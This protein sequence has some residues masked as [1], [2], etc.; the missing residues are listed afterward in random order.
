MNIPTATYRLQLNADFGFQHA[1]GITSY[2][3][4]LGISH[5]YAS[6]IFKARK[7]SP[8]GYDGVDPNQLNPE[9][10]S[11]EGFEK[12]TAGLQKHGIG[13]L[14]D[15]VP[16]HMAFDYEN[17]VLRDVLENGP[18]SQY[19]DFFDIAWDHPD[20]GMHRRLLAPFLGRPYSAC[21]ENGEIKL[22]YNATGFAVVY[23]DLKL[24]L[25]MASYLCILG[26]RTE[27][28]ETKLGA[29][30]EAFVRFIDLLD[31]LESLLLPMDPVDRRNQVQSI[32]ESLWDLYS[33]D[34]TIKN[35]VD[36]NLRRFNDDRT[37]SGQY[38]LL[39]QILSQ[40]MFRL[41]HWKV[42]CDEINYRRFFDI[43]ELITL[44]QEKKVVFDH[45]H[46]L[47]TNLVGD[48][49]VS[50][51]RI[52][53]IDGLRHPTDYLRRLRQRLG[54]IYVVVEKILDPAE[55]LPDFWPVQGTTGYEFS[56][57]VNG[58][59]IRH[60]NENKITEIYTR[61]SQCHD[62]FETV[63]A[64]CKRKVL[65]SQMA[66][67]LDNL[68]GV[69]KRLSARTRAGRD[70]TMRRLKDALTEILVRFPVY[71]TYIEPERLRNADDEVIRSAV[72]LSVLHRPDWRMELEF[73]QRLLLGEFGKE[74]NGGSSESIMLQRDMTAKFQQLTAPLMA[75]GME[76]TALYV[77]N[78]LLSLNEVGDHPS[79]FGCRVDAFHAFIKK[80]AEKWPY[81][82]N[83]TA[84]H[85]SKRGEDVRAR[86]NVLTEIPEE[87]EAVLK[88]WHVLN[89][90]KKKR[91]NGRKVPDKNE[92]YVL[93]QTL[94]G[95]FPL[96]AVETSTLVDRIRRYLIKA[97]REAKVHTSWLNPDETYEVALSS[98][99]EA[100]L[101][102]SDQSQF[103]KAFL[104][105]CRKVARYGIYN[106][107]SQALIK[108]T[109]PGVPD[110][111][112]GTELIDFHLV[113]PDNRRPVDFEKRKRYLLEI[114]TKVAS[115]PLHLIEELL[116]NREDG[117][118]K[119]FLIA[120]ALRTRNA[121]AALFQRGSYL[122]LPAAGRYKEHVIA[123]A[124]TYK[125]RCSIT[126]VPR[127]LT[128]LVDENQ[129]PLGNRVWRDT[130]IRLPQKKNLRWKN[131]FTE[132]ILSTNASLKIG[133]MLQHFPC[134]MLVNA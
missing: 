60:Q 30:H 108:I 110:L 105:F 101:S 52:D 38:N 14:Q 82:M 92:E 78:R 4:G 85:D 107:L 123:F 129:N 95:I 59:F 117:R 53:H 34:S 73:L 70:F 90:D 115:D 114:M 74:L 2:L 63:A 68:A 54:D 130:E 88:Q 131:V 45:T 124:R 98:F 103:L 48:G 43:N 122:P 40:Q 81:T 31:N 100:I 71:R 27:K 37:Q 9:L 125:H 112:Q 18:S 33:S 80:R 12:L 13:W 64:A 19:Y 109:A 89:R 67:D 29:E 35:F 116:A 41:C 57:V 11:S 49:I 20:E 111:Y 10:G 46:T 76:D 72:E 62:S 128:A 94:L 24:P 61:F 99:V 23:Y 1:A 113:D 55:S 15:I 26:H 47:L 93:Y 75:K 16:N 134:A 3:A 6:P 28:I 5:I 102:T 22:N 77:Y 51:L 121:Q 58:L 7:D 32:K 97:V 42:A 91:S 133:T 50:G 127:F 36:D 66:G 25:S 69:V 120:Q 84:T 65:K 118:I 104:P 79:R 8:H 86:I 106:S 132:E 44:R 126:V 17:R 21:L 39:D 83:N 87:W 56:P 96:D 119:L